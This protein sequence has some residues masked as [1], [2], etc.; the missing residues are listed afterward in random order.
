[1]SEAA[2]ALP[3]PYVVRKGD[4]LSGIARRTGRSL[5]DIRRWNGIKD[6][7]K[8]AV[9]QTLYL[10][11]QSAF[12]VS[13]LFL[14]ALRQPI[15]NLPFML[16]FDGQTVS[17]RTGATGMTARQVTRSA[18]SQVEVWVQNVEGLWQQISRT[19]SDYGHKLLTLVSGAVVVPGRTEPLPAGAP[20]RPV[21]APAGRTEAIKHPT[22][23]QPRAPKPAEGSPTKN[24]PMVKRQR[25]KGA[26]GQAVIEVDVDIPRGLLDLFALYEGSD[27]TEA[28]WKLAAES[29]ECEPAV[30][31]AF[32]EVESGGRSSFWRLNHG[33][34]AHVPAILFERHY[35]SRLTKHQYDA[36]H[37]DISWPVGYRPKKRLGQ[38]DKKMHD[39]KVDAG[40]VYGDY[41]SAYLRLINAFRLDPDAALQSCSWGKFQIMAS[42]YSLCG[43]RNARA[44]VEQMVRSE[45]AQVR[46][47]C[48]FIRRKP[49]GW[50]NP[51]NRSLGKEISLWD[52]VKTKNWP[53]IAYNYN[54]PAYRTFRY[55][56]KLKAAY[57]RYSA[58]VA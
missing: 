46:L 27:I 1:M 53:A 39:G 24:N 33:D 51:K 26:Q 34:G 23:S 41:S 40:D 31:K 16:K 32:A 42:N 4:T 13:A 44:L 12:G 54:G 49:A 11:E 6:P 45:L 10:S 28:D 55:D 58:S 18:E 25:T 43:H 57:E 20:P 21:Q 5:A 52:A 36:T 9:G 19:A 22:P 56:E 2:Q 37:P 35:F 14:D 17:G 7:N 38:D 8:L 50:K 15:A 3:D 48:E 47:V 29:I 30:L